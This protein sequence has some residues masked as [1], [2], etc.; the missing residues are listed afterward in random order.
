MSRAI[1]S[2][3]L[4]AG[5]LLSTYSQAA[6]PVHKCVVGGSITYQSSPCPT[7]EPRQRPTAEQL[8]A[9]RKKRAASAPVDEARPQAAGATGPPTQAEQRSSFRC[10]GRTHCSQM[11]SCAEAKYFLAN[12]PGVKMDGDRDGTPCE[13][14]WCHP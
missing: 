14:Q 1:G 2:I 7:G 13:Q 6:S 4:L 8:N 11:T 3:C 12:C 9:E 5:L 10:D